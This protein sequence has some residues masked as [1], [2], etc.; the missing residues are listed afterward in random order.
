MHL[1]RLNRTA[2]LFACALNAALVVRA[3]DEASITVQKDASGLV[4]HHGDETVRVSVCGPTVLHIVAGPGD[5]KG[6]SPFTP[7]LVKPCAPSAFDLTQSEK[8]AVLSTAE[9]KLAV[10]LKEGLLTFR[11]ARGD[12]LLTEMWRRPRVYTPEAVNGEKVLHVKNRFF[13]GAT[14]GFYGL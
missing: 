1:L 11:N 4:M 5:P 2:L 7:W 9:L 8:E 3:A 6:A 12:T 14:E 10:N 13:I